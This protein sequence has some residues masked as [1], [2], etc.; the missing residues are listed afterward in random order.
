MLNKDAAQHRITDYIKTPE[1][2]IE[3]IKYLA[4]LDWHSI[5]AEKE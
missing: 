1:E 3:T 5:Y 2:A 4:S